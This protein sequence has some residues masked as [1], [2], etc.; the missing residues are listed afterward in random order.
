MV[1][2]LAITQW[3]T[4]D[5]LSYAHILR[6]IKATMSSVAELADKRTVIVQMVAFSEPRWQLPRYLEMMEE[7]GT[8]RSVFT[9]APEGI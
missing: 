6:N 8:N 2:A 4:V 7:R 9:G 3:A 5:I 1:P